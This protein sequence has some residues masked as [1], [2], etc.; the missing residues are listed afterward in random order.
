MADVFERIHGELEQVGARLR[1]ALDLSRLHAERAGLVALRGRAAYQLGMVVHARER[2]EAGQ[3]G[4]FERL[5]ARMDDLTHQISEIERRI[6]EEEGRVET[7][8]QKPAPKAEE[9]D[10]EVG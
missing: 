4:E 8:H 10:A 7:V 2:G 6:G 9:A 1:S 5:I 3:P